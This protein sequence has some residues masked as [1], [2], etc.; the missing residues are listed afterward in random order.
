M[1][2]AQLTRLLGEEDDIE[3]VILGQ[4]SPP[5]GIRFRLVTFK[6][7]E[8]LVEVLDRIARM[9]GETRSDIIRRAIQLYIDIH[10]RRYM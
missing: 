10:T 8:E 7:P 4:D 3:L 2:Q 5:P 6:A 1:E 9:E